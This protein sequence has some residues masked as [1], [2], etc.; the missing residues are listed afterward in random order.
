MRRAG[1]ATSR[2]NARVPF[3][4]RDFDPADFDTLWRIDQNCFPAGISYSRA[5]LRLYMRR[6]AAFTLVAVSGA[7]PG[8]SPDSDGT[9]KL[10]TA[11]SPDAAIAGFI[12]AEA[13]ARARGHIITIDVIAEARRFGVGSLL[14]RAAEDR[15][16]TAGCRS[17][18]LETAV[19]NVSALSFYKR[20]G[21]SVIRTY[22]RYYSNGVD[23]LV[24]DRTLV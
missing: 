11:D 4:I 17:V 16:I 23:A 3:T 7:G 13:G 21:Y 18:E 6:R 5:E 22:P 24:L 19:D 10:Q 14:L 8:D 9:G 1:L 2:Y 15:L 20:H 12:V